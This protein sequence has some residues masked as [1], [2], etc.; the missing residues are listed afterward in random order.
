VNALDACVTLWLALVMPAAQSAD[1]L[2]QAAAQAM[3]DR[4]YDDAVAAYRDLVKAAPDDPETLVGL[5]GALLKARRPDQAIEP[6][7]RAV[8]LNAA[9]LAAHALLGSSYLAVGQ[10]AMA[11][12]PLERVVAA[13]PTDV[14]HRRMLA[15]AYSTSGR[16]L[17]ALK[18]RRRVT[19]A[20]PKQASGWY[21]LGQEYNALAEGAMSTFAGQPDDSPWRALILADSLSTRGPLPDAFVLFR[22]T[23][24]RLPD[25]VSIH[26]SIARIYERTGHPDWAVRER[27][28]SRAS[29]VDCARRRALCEFRAGRF[30]AA[31]DAALTGSDEE[32]QYWQIRSASE[33]ALSAF[34]KLD[35]LPDGI[36]RRAIRATRARA[37]ERFTDAVAEL[38]AALK[39]APGVPSLVFEL[40]SAQF[41]ARDYEQALA[42]VSPLLEQH[43]ADV[44]LLIM[45]GNS[46][47]ELRRPAEAIPLLRSVADQRPEDASARVALGR[48]YLQNGD[49]GQSV[50]LLEAQ[51]SADQDGSLHV[52]LARAYAALGRRDESAKLL[53]KSQ[54]LRTAA[55]E[56][57]K[58]AEQRT[59]TPP[60]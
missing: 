20:A 22:E 52:Q 42:T 46:L 59:I 8:S 12:A 23:L 6:L 27:E 28:R 50:P 13:R 24:E 39:F 14:E 25:M 56:R 33:L 35:A 49:Y 43:P 53:L 4:R 16:R 37:E 51:L 30:Q 58:A 26:D 40:A 10:P 1:A 32:S 29:P 15:E 17:D 48:A 9:L 57:R 3:S 19:T 47:L 45:A 7:E 34:A 60:K 2:R 18:E 36:E 55:D 41:A 5:G 54:E 11:V 44:R 21:E 38:Q 31:F